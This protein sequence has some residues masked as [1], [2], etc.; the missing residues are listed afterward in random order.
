MRLKILL[1]SFPLH[2]SITLSFRIVKHHRLREEFK[3]LDFLYSSFR[4]FHS[5]K[6]DKRLTLG[7][8]IFLRNEV[9]DVA[10]F[11]KYF[12]ERFFELVWFYAFFK[13]LDLD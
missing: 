6:D 2:G 4:G 3:A 5:I 11:R 7:F 12:G 13:V 10:I 9:D 8:E 1:L